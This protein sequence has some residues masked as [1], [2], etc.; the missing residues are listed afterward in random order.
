MIK[1]NNYIFSRLPALLILIMVALTFSHAG[2][3]PLRYEGD[4]RGKII[5]AKT[6]EPLL[7]VLVRM[8]E[9]DK[10]TLTDQKGNFIFSKIPL[11]VY[12]I[13]ITSSGYR[14]TITEKIEIFLGQSTLLNIEL[15]EALPSLQEHVTVIG[16][17]LPTA[18]QTSAS[19]VRLNAEE[20]RKMPGSFSDISRVLNIVPGT[21]HITE[22]TND[23]IVRGGSPWENGFFID[24][25]QIPNMNHFQTQ[26]S[27][28]GAIGIINVSL[29]KDI[30]FYTGGFS[31]AYGNRMSSIIDIR[32]K[33]GSRD[34]VHS[35][36]NL[37]IT[38]FGI[39]VEGPL[40]RN[41]GSWIL[42]LRRSYYDV[43]AKMIGY[44][45]APRFGDLHFKLTYEINPKNKISVLNIYGDS[46]LSFDLEQAVEA[47]FNSDLI[48]NTRQNTFGINWLLSWNN[49]GY[50]NTSLSYSF[51]KNSYSAHTASSGTSSRDFRATD[52]FNGEINLRNVNYYHFHEKFK[53]EFGFE[54]KMEKLDF[55]NYFPEY[56]N[57]W[58]EIMP[59]VSIGAET[60]TNR[61]GTFITLLYNPWNS[62]KTSIGIRADYFTYNKHFLVSPRLSMSLS[63]SKKLSLSGAAGIFYQTL[64]LFLLS[65]NLENKKNRDPAATH[66]VLGL[67]Y[68]LTADTLFSINIFNKQYRDL[69]LTMEDQTRF[70]LDSGIDMAF[71]RTYEVILDS[72]KA[73]ARG[74]EFYLHKKMTKKIDGIFSATFFRSRF[75]DSL[76]VWRNRV[77]DNQYIVTLVGSYLPNDRWRFGIRWNLAGG[78]PYTPYNIERSTF[79][80]RA[81][82]DQDRI[83]EDRYPLYMTVNLRIERHFNFKKSYMYL[84]LGAINLL[85]RKNLDRYFWNRIENKMGFIYQ[86]PLLPVFG[87][88]YNF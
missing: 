1:I 52:E 37:D 31:A 58:E 4:L 81:I 38:G 16:K 80:N 25:I 3:I 79:N 23:L 68:E 28:G 41:K 48:F 7:N 20:V 8:I 19:T 54:T 86:A 11:G 60:S 76:G 57:R 53:V 6:K 74:I 13:E 21:S 50:S 64:P 27:S 67:S 56:M 49:R 40:G 32:L 47:G 5:D 85:N 2:V 35:R 26:A 43:I 29:I 61:S 65:G 55:N 22:K 88:E 73:L 84:Y 24:N 78:I 44:G 75:K 9:I 62:L 82:L 63:L 83:Y 30:N 72:G 51:F 12:S 33:E 18:S 77:N 70:I 42:S 46:R 71:F 87:I 10:K 36:L 17:S 14:K 66:V 34:K 45:V 15:E 69:P 39:G 59:A